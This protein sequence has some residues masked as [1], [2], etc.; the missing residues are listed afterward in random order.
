MSCL[1]VDTFHLPHQR[2]R[3]SSHISKRARSRR[4][5]PVTVSYSALLIS[6]R[7][8]YSVLPLHHLLSL[9][10]FGN[11]LSAT[12]RDNFSL[13]KEAP[14]TH[15]PCWAFAFWTLRYIDWILLGGADAAERKI[16]RNG[17]SRHALSVSLEYTYQDFG[18]ICIS[19]RNKFGKSLYFCF[20]Q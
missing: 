16:S 9:G 13:C 3:S 5:P 7:L 17:V 8:R 6:N 10:V 15:N 20:A 18:L 19:D 11:S 1:T 2:I 14:T 12:F 4:V